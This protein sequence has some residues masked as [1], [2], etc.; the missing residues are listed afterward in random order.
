[1]QYTY[2]PMCMHMMLTFISKIVVSPEVCLVHVA[3]SMYFY[4]YG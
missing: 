4:W 2:T 3:S 1:M